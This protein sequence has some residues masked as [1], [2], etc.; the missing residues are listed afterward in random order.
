MSKPKAKGVKT[1]PPLKYSDV[2]IIPDFYQNIGN[3]RDDVTDDVTGQ[4]HPA[5][6]IVQGLRSRDVPTYVVTRNDAKSIRDLAC[7]TRD[8]VAVVEWGVGNGLE[9]KVVVSV[10]E[11]RE[12]TSGVSGV[13]HG[14]SRCVSQ[15]IYV[16]CSQ[17]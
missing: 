6:G 4:I 1:P 14:A 12:S 7:A 8:A 15:L 16:K 13:L 9:R 17:E 10:G 3:L 5:T 11:G 2:M